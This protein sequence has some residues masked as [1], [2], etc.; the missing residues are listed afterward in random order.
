MPNMRQRMNGQIQQSTPRF[1]NRLA[2]LGTSVTV[3]FV[4]LAA[5]PAWAADP[6]R[7]GP[8]ARPIK[9]QTSAVFEAAFLRGNYTEAK[10]LLPIALQADRSEPLA[11]TMG[12]IL[13]FYDDDLVAMNR[14]ALQTEQLGQR[15]ASTDPLRGNLYQAVGKSM[16]GGFDISKAGAGPIAGAPLALLKLQE[17]LQFLDQAE[18]VNPNDPELNLLRGFMEWGLSSILGLFDPNQ[19]RQRLDC[20]GFTG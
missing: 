2:T 10:Q 19:A 4:S 3:L 11:T 13:A 5:I 8:A 1:I 7:A 18:K 6:F 16:Q 14:Y 20:I 9:D 17:S 12:A 15:L